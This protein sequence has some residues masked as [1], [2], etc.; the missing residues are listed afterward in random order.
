MAIERKIYCNK[1]SIYCGVIRDASLR[2]GL[3]YI[4]EDCQNKRPIGNSFD[5]SDF[6]DYFTDVLSGKKK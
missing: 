3:I 1:C 4:C 5:S 6:M 2:K